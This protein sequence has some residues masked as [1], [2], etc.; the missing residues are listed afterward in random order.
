MERPQGIRIASVALISNETLGK[1]APAIPILPATNKLLLRL[2]SLLTKRRLFIETSSTIM[3]LEP[4]N[5]RLLRLTSLLTKRRLF[6]ETSSTNILLEPTNNR[7]L[8]LTSLLTKRRLFIETSS[9][10]ILLEPTNNRLLRLTSLLTKRRLLK[11]ASPVVCNVVNLPV[12]A[13]LAP[14]AVP[15]IAPLLIFT[16]VIA[17]SLKSK[18]ALL[19]PPKVSLLLECV[20]VILLSLN[21]IT[22][23]V[24]INKSLFKEISPSISNFLLGFVIPIPTLPLAPNIFKT[25][26]LV[27]VLFLIQNLSSL[28]V[29]KSQ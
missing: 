27:V 15:S 17:L 16:L 8:R 7:L 28:E 14:I 12:D 26:L 19:L 25:S 1:T 18:V 20:N 5:K 2:T 29:Y 3:V 4:T 23:P 22:R 21:L 6:I 13:L 9:T 24:S 10:N 11:E